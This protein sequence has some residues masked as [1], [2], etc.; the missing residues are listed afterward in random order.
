M[1]GYHVKGDTERGAEGEKRNI[2]WQGE[3]TH[4]E[5]KRNPTQ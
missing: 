5:D 3:I 4:R 2:F 1:N